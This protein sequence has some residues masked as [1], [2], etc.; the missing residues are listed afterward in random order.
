[1]TTK[2]KPF[3]HPSDYLLDQL[4]LGELEQSKASELREHVGSC[5]HCSQRQR[6]RD[7][8]LSAFPEVDSNKLLSRVLAATQAVAET[9]STSTNNSK[10]TKTTW[11]LLLATPLLCAAALLLFLRLPSNES[12][13][14][15]T[16]TDEVRS[17][18]NL[19]LRV[20]RQSS[21]GSEELIS[22]QHLTQGVTIGFVV[23]LPVHLRSSTELQ[24]MLISIEE[25]G[26]KTSVYYPS[27]RQS[28]APLQ[29]DS[30]GTLPAAIELDSYVGQE[31][32]RLI[33]CP[34]AF[35]LSDLHVTGGGPIGIDP[36]HSDSC[37]QTLFRLDKTQPQ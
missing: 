21:H 30:D 32:L 7:E 10:H 19:S 34:N 11:W 12:E 37:L 26:G 13:S 1:M 36:K 20:F 29:L 5:L 17:K 6:L 28:S 14:G 33:I 9:S 24:A 16:I 31:T 22:G 25:V 35:S 2:K 4:Y 18:G 23:D 3:S 27:G 15:H 8:G